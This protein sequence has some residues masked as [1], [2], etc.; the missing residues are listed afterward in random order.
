MKEKCKNCPE[1]AVWYYLPS[2]ETEKGKEPYYCDAHVPR[3]CDCNLKP[4]DGNY[5]NSNPDNWEEEVDEE[6]RKYPC[7]EYM[8]SEDGFE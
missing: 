1:D 8:F 2:N 4:K 6:G 5:E 7:C 3:G